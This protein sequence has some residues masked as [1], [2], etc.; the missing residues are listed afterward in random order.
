M[1]NM[2]KILIYI[3]LT[4]FL[5]INGCA[6]KKNKNIITKD[7]DT[8]S[9]TLKNGFIDQWNSKSSESPNYI[10]VSQKAPL[11]TIQVDGQNYQPSNMVWNE[12][13]QQVQLNYP[14]P[15]VQILVNVLNKVTHIVFEVAAIDQDDKVELVIWGPF[16]T[17]INRT[18]G[19]IVGVVRDHEYAIGIQTLNPKT[20]AG[21]PTEDDRIPIYRDYDY[22]HYDKIH[23]HEKDNHRFW[24]VAAKRTDFGSLLQA[25]CRNRT[26]E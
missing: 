14:E 22:N 17:T 5:I 24:G 12:E 1:Q 26:N 10:P 7:G 2:N 6:E 9:M 25:Y 23:F 18:I 11:L 13:K 16:P 19:E 3:Y 20:I 8:F 15:Q 4:L 21:Y